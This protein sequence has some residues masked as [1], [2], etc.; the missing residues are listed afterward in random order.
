VV[1][2]IPTKC[3]SETPEELKAYE[4]QQALRTYVTTRFPQ[5][6]TEA[7]GVVFDVISSPRDLY[8]ILKG[9]YN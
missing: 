9:Y 4:A 7:Q 5:Y 2:N 8:N 1:V 3:F 6:K